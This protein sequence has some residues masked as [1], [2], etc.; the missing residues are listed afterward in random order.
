MFFDLLFTLSVE[1]TVWS[2]VCPVDVKGVFELHGQMAW[3]APALCAPYRFI[4]QHSVW[5]GYFLQKSHLTVVLVEDFAYIALT[6]LAMSLRLRSHCRHIFAHMWPISHFFSLSLCFKRGTQRCLLRN[7][8]HRDRKLTH[9]TGKTAIPP[10]WNVT[11]TYGPCQRD[12]KH[13]S[14]FPS[15]SKQPSRPPPLLQ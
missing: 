14:H 7:H 1:H 12:T 5:K 13:L 11:K 2:H 4:V 10:L 3:K 15:P 8:E 9:H 6:C